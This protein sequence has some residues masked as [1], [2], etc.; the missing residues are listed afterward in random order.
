VLEGQVQEAGD[1]G[2]Y[3]RV[4]ARDIPWTTVGV[5]MFLLITSCST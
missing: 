2:S 5:E 4:I 1:A 3:A